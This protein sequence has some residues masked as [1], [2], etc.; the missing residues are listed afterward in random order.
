MPKEK[1]KRSDRRKKERRKFLTEKEFKKLIEEGKA[2]EK[3]KRL[4]TKR[5]TK[6]RRA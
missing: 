6:K 1:R 4:Y 5:R 3:D 2:T